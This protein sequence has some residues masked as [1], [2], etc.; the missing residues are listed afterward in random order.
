M[1][2]PPLDDIE[3]LYGALM[4]A[5]DREDWMA[6]P[7]CLRALVDH[8]KAQQARMDALLEDCQTKIAVAFAA[9]DARQVALEEREAVVASA[10]QLLQGR[11]WDE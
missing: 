8:F 2:T 11:T 1:L 9:L 3:R 7:G 5:L 10:A 6:L 4:Q